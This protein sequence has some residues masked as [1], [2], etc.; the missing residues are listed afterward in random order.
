MQKSYMIIIFADVIG[1]QLV[2]NSTLLG[3]FQNDSFQLESGKKID[4]SFIIPTFL[5]FYHYPSIKL[6]INPST[7]IYTAPFSLSLS[8]CLS[9]Y[10]SLFVVSLSLFLLSLDIVSKYIFFLHSSKTFFLKIIEIWFTV[11]TGR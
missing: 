8:I 2:E 4:I 3:K 9:I 7:F 6:F 1:S 10:V 5:C 11:Q